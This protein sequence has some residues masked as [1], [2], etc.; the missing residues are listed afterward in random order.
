MFHQILVAPEDRCSQRFL[1]RECESQPPDVYEMLVMTFGAACSPCIAQYVKDTNA[2]RFR[3]RFPRAVSS[4]LNHH[5]VD[6][7]V[8]SFESTAKAIEVAQQVREIH[9]AAGYELR[10]FTSSSAEVIASRGQ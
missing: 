5:Y 4:I 1:W 2:L 7:F 8:D 3:D 6:D 10:N 9:A